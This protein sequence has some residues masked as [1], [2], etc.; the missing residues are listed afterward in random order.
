[1]TATPWLKART[2]IANSVGVLG[3]PELGELLAQ[4]G[5]E[6]GETGGGLAEHGVLQLGQLGGEGAHGA[7]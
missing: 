4:P 5:A 2:C 3:V 1:M 7:A 6:Q